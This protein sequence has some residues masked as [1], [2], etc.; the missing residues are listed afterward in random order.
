MNDLIKNVN[1][2]IA[3]EVDIPVVVKIESETLY[4]LLIGIMLIIA[5]AIVLVK[6]L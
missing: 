6:K 1:K 4:P 2:L 3:G 5:T